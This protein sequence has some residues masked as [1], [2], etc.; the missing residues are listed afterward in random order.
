VAVD[1]AAVEVGGDFCTERDLALR[2]RAVR[3]P[4]REPVAVELLL[5]LHERAVAQLVVTAPVRVDDVEAPVVAH[6][7]LLHDHLVG[8]DEPE[9]LD[10]RDRD[11]RDDGHRSRLRARL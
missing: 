1:C 9:T 6:A 10:R 8:V 11:V 5:D 2:S 4:K 7:G 3:E